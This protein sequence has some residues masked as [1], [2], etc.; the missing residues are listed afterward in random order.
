ME[1][2][3]QYS[4]NDWKKK[5]Q[6]KSIEQLKHSRPTGGTALTTWENYLVVSTTP[7]YV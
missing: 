7:G 3:I 6:V 1:I 5:P 4:Q 2:K